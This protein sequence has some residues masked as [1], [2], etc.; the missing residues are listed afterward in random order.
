MF[1]S[2]KSCIKP[3]RKEKPKEDERQLRYKST[4]T[5]GNFTSIATSIH[6][7]VEQGRWCTMEVI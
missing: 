6:C 4:E 3:E 2:T 7:H 5:G 1:N